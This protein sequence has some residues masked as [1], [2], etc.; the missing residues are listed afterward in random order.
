[1]IRLVNYNKGATALSLRNTQIIALLCMFVGPFIFCVLDDWL[2]HLPELYRHYI[3]AT[4]VSVGMVIYVA[5]VAGL[6]VVLLNIGKPYN[7]PRKGDNQ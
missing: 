2:F 3:I 1:M 4:A 6:M 7:K 5:S